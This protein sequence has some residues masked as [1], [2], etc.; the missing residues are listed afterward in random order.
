[1]TLL[2]HNFFLDKSFIVSQKS[3][4]E[5]Y[6]LNSNGMITS[7]ILSVATTSNSLANKAAINS[8]LIYTLH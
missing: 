8:A 5:M 3:T 6:W 4:Y 7:A 2:L 1:M